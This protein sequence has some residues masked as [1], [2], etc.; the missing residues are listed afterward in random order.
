MKILILHRIPY[1]KIDYHRGI[2]HERHDVVYFGKKEALLTLPAALRCTAVERPGVASALDE[3]RQWL[4]A[5]PQHFDRVISLSEYELL[6]AAHLREWLDVP[7]APVEQVR[8]ARDKMLMKEAVARA[9]LRVPRFLSL[10]EFLASGG[11]APWQP[12]TVLKPHSGA[13]S[14]DV[15]IFPTAAEAFDALVARRSGVVSLDTSQGDPSG[16]EVEEFISGPILHFDGLVDNGQVTV[17]TA[18]EYVG[19]CLL[20]ANGHPLGSYHYP[21][22]DEEREWVC[23]AL[24]ATGINSGSFHLEAIR[25][26]EDLVFLEVANRVGG[27]DVVRTF[28]LATGIHLPSQELKIFMNEAAY[29]SVA[30]VSVRANDRW[31]GWFVYPGHH[32]SDESNPGV[33]GTDA[34][35]YSESMVHWHELE[36]GAVLKRHITYQAHEVP[37][38]GVVVTTSAQTTRAWMK[39]L[40]DSV[41]YRTTTL[42]RHAAEVQ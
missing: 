7:G 13:S 23:S 18:S 37:L 5:N 14:E 17:M 1:Q 24:R 2:D 27:A 16:Y 10:P 40:F 15:V 28:E 35:R 20:F 31:H 26:G 8:L 42:P 22:D 11:R 25:H 32:L 12:A 9:G 3:A 33:V 29:A 39:T 36:Q 38:A 4:Q 34:F 21:L 41:S 30:P 19:N 6:D